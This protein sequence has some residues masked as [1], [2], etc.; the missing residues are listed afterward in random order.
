M[1]KTQDS[2]I[3]LD[4]DGVLNTEA[5][6]RH[7][8][9]RGLPC[10]DGFGPVF[11]PLAVENL[12]LILSAVPGARIVITSSWRWEGLE[13]MRELWTRR[14]L[15]G[16]VLD[17]A[18]DF[19]PHFDDGDF[20]KILQGEL[21]VGRGADIRAWLDANATEGAPYVI[22]DDLPDFFPEQLPHYVR[23]DPGEGLSVGDA[24]KAIAILGGT[25][26]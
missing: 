18:P 2:F 13:T 21:P 11:D 23:T 6:Q 19:I 14:G 8:R 26:A 3:F 24:M 25:N 7:C 15:P 16:T 22:L 17:I 12:S 9:V 4:F 10:E 20:E 5:W 1:T